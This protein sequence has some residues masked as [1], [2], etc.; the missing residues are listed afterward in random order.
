ML[1]R[2]RVLTQPGDLFKLLQRLGYGSGWTLVGGVNIASSTTWVLEGLG[3]VL[4][5]A[6]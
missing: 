3:I 2:V 5:D 1:F 4:N 6:G